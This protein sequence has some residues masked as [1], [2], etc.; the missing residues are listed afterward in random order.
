MSNLQNDILREQLWEKAQEI[1]EKMIED[2]EIN[3]ELKEDTTESIY[4]QLWEERDVSI[5]TEMDDDSE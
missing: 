5:E 1:V 3:P 4:N 2:K